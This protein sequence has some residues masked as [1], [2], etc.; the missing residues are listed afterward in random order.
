MR[1]YQHHHSHRHHHRPKTPGT[2]RL[3]RRSRRPRPGA[4]RW[5]V[6][7]VEFVLMTTEEHR[8]ATR[9]LSALFAEWITHHHNNGTN[10]N[11]DHTPKAAA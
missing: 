8:A 6:E 9:A 7:R 2:V 10:P 5:R 1:R 11:D 3:L 4:G